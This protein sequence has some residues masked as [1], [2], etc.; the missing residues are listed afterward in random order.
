MEA[1]WPKTTE[2]SPRP[3]AGSWTL[4]STRG[5]LLGT[6]FDVTKTGGGT[7]VT[8]AGSCGGDGGEGG[9]PLTPAGC[10]PNYTGCVPPYPPDVDCI[11]VRQEVEIIG[12][13]VHRLDLGGDGEAC[14][15]YFK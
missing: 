9:V 4:A 14:E 13:D 12:E 7:P 15:I 10:D 5:R 11:D 8:D 3:I 2:R 6:G 1:I